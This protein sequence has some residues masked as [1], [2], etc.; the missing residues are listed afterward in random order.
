MRKLLLLF[1]LFIIAT[2]VSAS[3]KTYPS[4]NG[5]YNVSGGEKTPVVRLKK[6]HVWDGS[7]R[8]YSGSIFL[9]RTPANSGQIGRDFSFGVRSSSQ[10]EGQIAI[11]GADA[12]FAKPLAWQM[13]I[14]AK[15]SEF[16]QVD[17]FLGAN[18][19]ASSEG[20]ADYTNVM[21]LP[22]K[23]KSLDEFFVFVRAP[24]GGSATVAVDNFSSSTKWIAPK[25]TLSKTS[26]SPSSSPSPSAVGVGVIGLGSLI[27]LALRRAE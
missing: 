19:I 17:L 11:A 22:E 7:T 26:P 3:V 23:N 2:G 20:V 13:K 5:V 4:F 25:A 10:T 24:S 12:K 9:S 21:S 1:V 6:G 16:A 18:A 8:Y 15:D 27:F 14:H